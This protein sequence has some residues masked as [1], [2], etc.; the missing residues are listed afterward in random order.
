M[1]TLVALAVLAATAKKSVTSLPVVHASSGC[2]VST[3]AGNYA[4]MQPAGFTAAGS[5]TNGNEVPWQ[6]VGVATFDGAGKV[7]FSYTAVINGNVFTNQTSSGTYTLNSNTLNSIC[8][9]SASFTSGEGA[10]T[11]ANIVI[12]GGGTEVFGIVTNIGSTASFDMKKQ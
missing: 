5:S 2:S 7:I 10:G 8:N 12:V 1:A 9:G 6:F 4:V 11:D 3:L